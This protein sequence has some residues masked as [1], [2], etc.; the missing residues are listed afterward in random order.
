MT[1]LKNVRNHANPSSANAPK[2]IKPG[3]ITNSTPERERPRFDN[4]EPR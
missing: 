2:K 3:T 1:N 4:S